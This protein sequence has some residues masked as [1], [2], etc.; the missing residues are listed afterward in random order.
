[1]AN[2]S[3]KRDRAQLVVLSTGWLPSRAATGLFA[4]A[5]PLPWALWL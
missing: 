3:W 1:M 2:E 5:K 4:F